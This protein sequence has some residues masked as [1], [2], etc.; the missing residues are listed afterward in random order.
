MN[1]FTAAESAAVMAAG[2]LIPAMIPASLALSPD[3]CAAL[4]VLPPVPALF[5]VALLVTPCVTLFTKFL[6]NWAR[7]AVEYPTTPM[8]TTIKTIACFII[9]DLSDGD[10]LIIGSH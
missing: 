8:R 6:R 1:S 7:A 5:P 3:R 2:L 9:Q 10:P 4:S